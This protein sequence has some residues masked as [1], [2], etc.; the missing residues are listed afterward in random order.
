MSSEKLRLKLLA[1][2]SKDE[3]IKLNISGVHVHSKSHAVLFQKPAQWHADSEPSKLR[4]LLGKALR[5]K[6][7]S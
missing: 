2:C 6:F 7:K 5:M 1:E 3:Y 4:F